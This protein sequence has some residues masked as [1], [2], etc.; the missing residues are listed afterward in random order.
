M[1]FPSFRL[2]HFPD[3][4]WNGFKKWS[5]IW[6]CVTTEFSILMTTDSMWFSSF[7]TQR[8]KWDPHM[9][10]HIYSGDYYF[11]EFRTS[12]NLHRTKIEACR[13]LSFSPKRS[14]A[15]RARRSILLSLDFKAHLRSWL[16]FS[17]LERKDK[18]VV[19]AL[20]KGVV[21]C[22]SRSLV[23]CYSPHK[24]KLPSLFDS[25]EEKS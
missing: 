10:F 23:L 19:W 2:I 11:I 12:G 8:R 15:K 20:P 4:N 18:L 17:N 5:T 9:S 3:I 22:Y 21:V 7:P 14:I 25:F 16:S 6:E 24:L 1:A 13:N